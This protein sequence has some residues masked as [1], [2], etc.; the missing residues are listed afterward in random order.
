MSNQVA[1]DELF[2]DIERALETDAFEP[3]FQPVA[4]LTDGGCRT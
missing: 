3:V 1:R 2:R 4:R